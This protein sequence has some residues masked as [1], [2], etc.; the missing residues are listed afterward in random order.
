MI[1][2]YTRT[3]EITG[4]D[5]VDH[6]E[7]QIYYDR[8]EGYRFAIHDYKQGDFWREY[9]FRLNLG[10]MGASGMVLPCS[11]QSKKRYQEAKSMLDELEMRFLP[12]YASTVGFEVLYDTRVDSERDR[13]AK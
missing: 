9:H 11:R 4:L 10:G 7:T 3:Y 6:V 5:D 1:N 8:G 2:E 12:D 13:Y